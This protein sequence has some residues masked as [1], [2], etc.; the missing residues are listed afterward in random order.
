MTGQTSAD[1]RAY[2]DGWY[3]DMAE[4][5]A[6]D[7][8]HQRH[9]GLPAGWH[10]NNT[11]PWAGIGEI[12][13]I[14]G[15][16]AGGVL[17][18]LGCGRGAI[19]VELAARADAAVYGIDLSAVALQAA[20]ATA[21]GRGV[22]HAYAAAP[23]TT[24]GLRAASVDAAICIDS[25]QFAGAGLGDELRRVLRP[26]GRVVLTCWRAT[27]PGDPEV[28][29]KI[30]DLDLAAEL[31]TAGFAAVTVAEPR[32]WD[33]AEQAM[34]AEAAALEPGDDAALRSMHEEGVR[35]VERGDRL[36]R[37]LVSAVR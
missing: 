30:R 31:D 2:W 28:P 7:V 3:A 22:R 24:T 32:H 6:R 13:E 33:A 5:P 4:R 15:L 12:A 8:L 34:W 27:T 10:A 18:D 19:G 35:A 16:D 17:L 36:R 23:M 11:V 14:L 37:I 1:E 21:R 9:L 25:A 20:R 29:A 26:G